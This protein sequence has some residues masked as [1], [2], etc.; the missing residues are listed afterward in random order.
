MAVEPATLSLPWTESEEVLEDLF[1]RDDAADDRDKHRKRCDTDNQAR[2]VARKGV[3]FVVEPV[4]KVPACRFS[5]VEHL[6]GGC[7]QRQAFAPSAT[8]AAP[9]TTS[10]GFSLARWRLLCGQALLKPSAACCCG[11]ICRAFGKFSA[12]ATGSPLALSVRRAG[13]Y[14]AFRC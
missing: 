8:V 10:A 7:I 6:A 3:E 5:R 11:I 12:A 1:M 4:E 14:R 9:T 2:P 13:T